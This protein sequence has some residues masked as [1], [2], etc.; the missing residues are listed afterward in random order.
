MGYR[1]R[2]QGRGRSELGELRFPGLPDRGAHGRVERAARVRDRAGNGKE[3]G[4]SQAQESP[5]L[6][7]EGSPCLRLG[8]EPQLAGS[9]FL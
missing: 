2:R 3:Q 7:V 8:G 1:N 4:H 6:P 9:G 5:G